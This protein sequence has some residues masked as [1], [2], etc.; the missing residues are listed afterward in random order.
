MSDD[1][2]DSWGGA[3][4]AGKGS[5][6][7]PGANDKKFSDNYDAIFRKK[8]VSDEEAKDLADKELWA[9]QEEEL[10][11][12]INIIGTNGGDGLHYDKMGEDDVD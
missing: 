3:S 9:T 7:R 6:R 4:A 5:Y 11:R 10:E 12:R 1:R 2:R 8:E